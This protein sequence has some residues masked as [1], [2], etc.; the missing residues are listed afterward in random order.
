MPANEYIS[1]LDE[2]HSKDSNKRIDHVCNNRD[3]NLSALSRSASS[4][5]QKSLEPHSTSPK[6]ILVVQEATDFKRLKPVLVPKAEMVK[7]HYRQ[8]Q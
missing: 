2:K 6:R 5:R 7:Q 4:K 3:G 8:I 1:L